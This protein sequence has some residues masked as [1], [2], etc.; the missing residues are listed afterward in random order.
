MGRKVYIDNQ[1]LS[2]ARAAYLKHLEE[3]GAFGSRLTESI[4]T[5]EARGRVTA[6]PVFASISSPHYNA[7]AMDGIAVRAEDTFGASETSP[8]RLKLEEQGRVV[9]TGDPLPEGFNA[10]IMIEE[11]SFISPDEFEIIQPA[12]PWQ[13]V[14]LVGE[15][16]VAG[17]MLVPE[18]C[19]LRS[20]E[21]G[22]LLAGGAGQVTVL[23]KPRVAI[24][25]TG[26]ELVP[27]GADLKPGDIIEF[28]SHLLGGMMEEW[29]AE[30]RTIP[31]VADDY[32]ALKQTI[33]E[34]MPNC[35]LLIINAGSSA[36]REDFTYKLVSELGQV[37]V[38]G[39]AIRPG[40]P[41][42]LGSIAGKPV[43]GL[44][45]YPVSA[46]LT[47]ELFARPVIYR[48]QGQPEPEATEIEARVNRKVVSSLGVDEFLRVKVG[49][50]GE[51][52]IATPLP[53]GAGTITSLTKA[54]GVLV[55]PSRWEGFLAGDEVPIILS[56]PLQ[57]IKNTLAIIG[58]HDI[59]LDLI[60]SRIKG[61]HPEMSLS[62]AHVGSLGG[63]AALRRKE[64]HLAGIHLLDEETG[65]YNISYIQ[66]ILPGIPVRLVN[67]AYRQ[68]GLMVKSGNPLQIKGIEDLT[69]P[70]VQLVN[71]QRGAG[72][73]ILLDYELKTRGI[74]PDSI[75]GYDRE[76][77][78]HMAVAAA[79]ASGSADCGM[80]IL[81]AARALGLDFVPVAVERYD[82]CIPLEHWEHGTV[83]EMLEVLNS[84]EFKDSV[85]ELGGY[86]L[87]DCGRVLWES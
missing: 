36:G 54:D 24:L 13:H 18:N 6:R 79:V 45:G 10:V 55:V 15:D 33:Q 27:P 63:L 80:G 56:R 38:H 83:R 74:N 17:E 70:G 23:A 67:L 4:P 60:G 5:I 30:V 25:P 3:T 8:V 72:T 41:V 59:T 42:I 37:T 85:V 22:A 51:R 76:E 9:D 84:Q 14:R 11:I 48:W 40:K 57:E 66:R 87:R 86:D 53:R 32:Q 75:I 19:L 31:M 50:V 29:G 47:A 52:V 20:Y 68:Q 34:A 39:V 64:A 21:I 71:R 28:N 73:R 62:S 7:S 69:R 46:A 43:I 16:V 26:T 1:P 49:M 44:P 82:L 78:T 12:S 77:H 81:A 65:E 58:S 35:D 61:R 2:E